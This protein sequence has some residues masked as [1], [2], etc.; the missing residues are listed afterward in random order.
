[1]GFRKDSYATVWSVTPMSSTMTKARISID[2]KN[3]ET[4]QY[5]Q[6][7]GGF[8]IFVGTANAAKAMK[9]KERDRIRL[10]DVDVTNRYD[11]EKKIEYTSFKIFSFDDANSN[12]VQDTSSQNSSSGS[13]TFDSNPHDGDIEGWPF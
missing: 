2:R 1:M 7:F 6:E 11:K 10:G 12:R 8:V 4:G 9:L 3:K 5:E 13:G